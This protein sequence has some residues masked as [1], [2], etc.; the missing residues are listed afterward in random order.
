MNRTKYLRFIVVL[1]FVVSMIMSIILSLPQ[2]WGNVSA[3]EKDEI[4]SKAFCLIEQGSGRVLFENESKKHLPMASVTKTMTLLLTFEAIEEG[5]FGFDDK[6]YCS[7]NASGMGGSQVFLDADTEYL[8][9][10]LLYAVVMSSANDA[11]VVFAEKIAG[12]EESFVDLMNKKAKSLGLSDTNFVNCTGLPANNHYSCAYDLAII[13]KELLNHKDYFKYTK[14]RL[15]DF[16]HPSGRITQMTNTN[17][18]LKSYSGC[19]AGK[20]GSTV[21][22]GYCLSAT[23]LKNNMRL[24]AVV[25][26]AENTKARFED[27]AKVFDYGFNN[28]KSTCLVNNEEKQ[29]LNFEVKHAKSTENYVV[30]ERSYYDVLGKDEESKVSLDVKFNNI[31][32]PAKKG[33]IAG[34]VYVTKNNEIYEEINL[35]LC[36]DIEART[37]FEELKQIAQKW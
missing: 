35:V 4:N 12:S 2:Q 32:A 28:F 22:A 21:E 11:S 10:D 23:A 5:K 7:K 31:T 18:L 6:L 37:Y 19:D 17:K 24:I 14:E 15:R 34:I 25:L 30:P 1:V 8:I 33:D 9:D 27:A 16:V 26:G 3:L 29:L 20:T 13:M 36:D